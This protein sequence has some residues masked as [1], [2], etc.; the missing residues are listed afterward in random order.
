MCM[1]TQTQLHTD[2]HI[3]RHEPLSKKPTK[4]LTIS[5]LCRS[6]SFSVPEF[7]HRKYYMYSVQIQLYT[8]RRGRNFPGGPVVKN[9]PSNTAGC[10]SIPGQGIRISHT[11]KPMCYND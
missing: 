11:T 9:L 4:K 5:A 3:N 7:P 2:T 6:G 1:H 10:G 8:E